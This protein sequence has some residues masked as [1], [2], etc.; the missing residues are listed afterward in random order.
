MARALT[1]V[2]NQKGLSTCHLQVIWSNPLKI[3][4]VY[5]LTI[6]FVWY[7]KYLILYRPEQC[8]KCCLIQWKE[9]PDKN[10][11]NCLTMIVWDISSSQLQRLPA[12]LIPA[13]NTLMF[14]PMGIFITSSKSR[15]WTIQSMRVGNTSG[16]KACAEQNVIHQF[17]SGPTTTK[18]VSAGFFILIAKQFRLPDELFSNWLL[19][20]GFPR[21]L[22]SGGI[23]NN[24]L[25]CSPIV[26]W[27]FFWGDKDVMEGDKIVTWGIPH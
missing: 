9:W 6:D 17:S 19:G 16:K 7:F 12:N 27:E 20:P 23:F 11:W 21:R 25:L 18:T 4:A 13:F 24:R 5:S 8:P 22:K 26:F 1:N 15:A 3:W 2:T 10:L 14:T